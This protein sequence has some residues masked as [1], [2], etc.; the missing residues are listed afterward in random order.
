MSPS[1]NDL[2]ALADDERALLAEAQRRL[3]VR[4]G[5]D[6]RHA[7]AQR[8]AQRDRL[9]ALTRFSAEQKGEVKMTAGSRRAIFSSRL[10]RSGNGALAA[11]ALI[12]AALG[13]EFTLSCLNKLADPHYVSDFD[14]FVRST[15][16]ASSGWLAPLVQALVLPNVALF[17]RLIE[18]GELLIGIVLLI[19]ALD[20][21]RRRLAGQLGAQHGY[22]AP[23]ALLSAIA[24]LAAAGLTLSI[25]VLMGEGFPG[26]AAGR[27]FSSAV[28]IELFIVPLGLAIAWLELGRFRVLRRSSPTVVTP[29]GRL[30]R[31]PQ[32]A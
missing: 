2:Q 6:Q 14:G 8:R 21:G 19:G 32:G 23:L 3:A 1:A 31:Q 20:I 15:P 28:P 30:A 7:A 5:I 25:G 29:G 16:G 22:E 24:G 13:V 11:S 12:Q 10:P 18:V 26:V 9:E 17:A 27:A 4:D